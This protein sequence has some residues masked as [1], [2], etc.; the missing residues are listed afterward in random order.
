MMNRIVEG[1]GVNFDYA[2]S[3]NEHTIKSGDP[4]ALS[5]SYISYGEKVADLASASI[6]REEG[7]D[8]PS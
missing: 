7:Q 2:T 6:Q 4:V 3:T 8:T 5:D 1:S